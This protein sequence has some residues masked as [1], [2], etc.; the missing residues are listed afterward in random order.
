MRPGEM[1]PP[2]QS[3]RVSPPIAQ[4]MPTQVMPPVASMRT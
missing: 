1:T 2:G 4:L 3:I